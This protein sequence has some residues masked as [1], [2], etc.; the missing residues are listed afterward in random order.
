M[1][2]GPGSA[3][4]YTHQIIDELQNIDSSPQRVIVKNRLAINNE[5]GHLQGIQYQKIGNK[6]LVL[7][8]GSSNTYA[9]AAVA[10][11]GRKR[12]VKNLF[13]LFDKPLKHAGGFQ[14]CENYMAVG[15]E[16]NESRTYAEVIVY[17][18]S[19]PKRAPLEVQK[20]VRTGA[21]EKV[22]AGCVA[23]AKFKEHWML[24]VGNWNTRDLDIYLS[25]ATTGSMNNF[26][27]VQSMNMK[28]QDRSKWSDPHWLAYQNINLI[29][30]GN[31]LFLLGMQSDTSGQNV[32]DLFQLSTEDLKQFTIRKIS[33]KTLQN[34]GG[35]F[36]WGSGAII[37][38]DKLVGLLSCQRNLLPESTIYFYR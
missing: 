18:I 16:D 26:M 21:F 5:G 19:K 36:V 17:D 9:Y 27:L 28:E 33:S 25:P 12:I 37:Q 23:M 13:P 2:C 34:T 6:E 14:V 7:L 10:Q 3:Q 30:K 4:D 1:F 38:D 11:L 20:I 35:D 8:S 31:A 29:A 15:I 24:V 32:A 22:T